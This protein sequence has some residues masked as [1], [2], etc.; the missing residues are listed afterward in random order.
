MSI[1]TLFLLQLGLLCSADIA[2]RQLTDAE[3]DQLIKS[4]TFVGDLRL[5]DFNYSGTSP[6]LFWPYPFIAPA[7]RF[8]IPTDFGSAPGELPPTPGD[9]RP[10]E[11]LNKGRIEFLA[12]RY[13]SARR[14]WLTAKAK[15]GRN[16]P[17]HRRCDYFIGLSFVALAQAQQ[18]ESGNPRDLKARGLYAGAA[19]FLSWAF[20]LKS[21]PDPALDQ[22][23]PKALYTLAAIYQNH[24]R[25]SGAYGIA[26]KGLHFLRITGRSEYRPHFHRIISETMIRQHDYTRALQELDLT[27]R[28]DPNRRTAA[29]AFSRAG[30]LYFDLRNFDLAQAV[31]TT[32]S[33]LDERGAT[34][35][36]N[37]ILRGEALFWLRRY[38]EAA[39]VIQ[40]GIDLYS[41]PSVKEF[42][43]HDLLPWASLRV[44]DSVLARFAEKTGEE[45]YLTGNKDELIEKAKIA[46]YETSRIYPNSRAGKIAKI[47]L[48]CLELPHYRGNNTNHARHTL[49]Q[50][51]NWQLPY[52]AVE[53][54]HACY[55]GSFTI[56]E[57][58]ERM[59]SRIKK[60]VQHY[61]DS[62]FLNNLVAPIESYRR[63]SLFKFLEAGDLRKGIAYYDR[64]RD[65]L[66]D[67]LNKKE[68]SQMFRAFVDLS[69]TE[70]SKPFFSAFAERATTSHDFLRLATF[71]A[72]QGQHDPKWLAKL[73]DHDWQNSLLE[74]AHP[75]IDRILST[76]SGRQ[77]IPWIVDLF[78]PTEGNQTEPCGPDT[79]LLGLWSQNSAVGRR[80]KLRQLAETKVSEF[81]P[82]LLKK[83][84]QCAANLLRIERD[85]QTSSASYASKWL[86]RLD[87]KVNEVTAPF[88][89]QASV[90]LQSNGLESYKEIATRLADATGEFQEKTFAQVALDQK[91]P[92]IVKFWNRAP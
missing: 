72:E 86:E 6:E 89:W 52:E 84:L 76:N 28:Q 70:R 41:Y 85:V 49:E 65:R 60:F 20:S 67:D 19:T 61:P 62:E 71:L 64:F 58:D 57:R 8:P 38:E 83:D 31:Y 46:Y 34:N 63:R 92:E 91:T 43:Y 14:I 4:Y 17:Y 55:A 22:I 11:H 16:Y 21:E 66:F 42:D 15:Y 30:D 35:P 9:S 88:M 5:K 32:A 44:A 40:Y 18:R 23:A 78:R 69:L 90:T 77:N 80:E 12:G 3:F 39:K 68:Q 79:I 73:N 75:Y 54:A 53:L 56:S 47:R 10:I 87:W 81:L 13:D 74:L 24:E 33:S 2:A 48:A 59:I 36:V 45:S 26:E 51:V 27:I 25:L 37:H 82:D 1:R 50:A 7:D 29:D